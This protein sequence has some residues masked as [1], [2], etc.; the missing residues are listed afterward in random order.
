MNKQREALKNI[1]FGQRTTENYET[2]EKA[3]EA[4][5]FIKNC[6]VVKLTKPDNVGVLV[7][8]PTTLYVDAKKYELLKDI[9]IYL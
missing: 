3:L 9:G 5:E 7:V 2:V 8:L 6:Q 4:L 1:W